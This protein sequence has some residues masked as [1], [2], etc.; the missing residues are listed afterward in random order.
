M[1]AEGDGAGVVNERGTSAP[2]GVLNHGTYVED[3]PVTREALT[4]PEE[5]R[6]R[7]GAGEGSPTMGASAGARPIGQE[8]RPPAG[9][10][11]ARDNRSRGRRREGV[12]WP[13]SSGEVGKPV[14]AGSR[15]SE[16]GQC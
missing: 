1:L 13:C 7:R 12:G 2:G 8:K 3:G 15:R 16:G 6:F 10:P 9:R 5:V 4:V 14:G 11:K